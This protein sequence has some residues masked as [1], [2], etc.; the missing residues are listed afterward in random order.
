MDKVLLIDIG[1]TNIRTAHANVGS[2]NFRNAQKINL[3]NINLFELI[4]KDL[5]DKDS[6]IKH[7]VVSAAGPKIN[8]SISMTNRKL[9]IDKKYL[10]QKFKLNSCHI[11]NDWEAI[12]YSLFKLSNDSIEIIN[13]G[14]HFNKT[15]LVIGPGTGLGASIISD[16]KIV[17]PTEIGNSLFYPPQLLK[18]LEALD[19]NDLKIIEDLISGRGLAKIYLCLSGSKKSPEEIIGAYKVDEYAKKTIDLFLYSFSTI[20]SELAMTYLPGNGIFLT[21]G[22]MRALHKYLN[23]ESFILNFLRNRKNIH[24]ELLAQIP[25]SLINQEMT[26]LYGNLNFINKIYR[27]EN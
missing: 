24:K 17:L 18:E 8:D 3:E 22:L 1:G 16:N 19:I 6:S 15:A 14:N 5:I 9:K 7:L 20:L 23:I 2:S 12:G 27:N 4:L 13:K 11:L 21:G 25:L 26:C 10:L